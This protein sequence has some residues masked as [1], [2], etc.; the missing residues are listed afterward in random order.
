VFGVR[1]INVVRLQ[2]LKAAKKKAAELWVVPPCSPVGVFRL[3]MGLVA[4]S[5][6]ET[7]VNFYRITRR[8]SIILSSLYELCIEFGDV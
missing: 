2:V 3:F 5:S 6:S 1:N 8:I 4:K 7:S